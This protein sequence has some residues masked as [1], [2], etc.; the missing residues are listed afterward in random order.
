MSGRGGEG[1]DHDAKSCGVLVL[2]LG[3]LTAFEYSS[4]VWRISL[5]LSPASPGE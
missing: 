2:L 1:R 3:S 5:L 4:D